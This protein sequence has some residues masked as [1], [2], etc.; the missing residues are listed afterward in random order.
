MAS[1]AASAASAASASSAPSIDSIGVIGVIDVIDTI[2][3]LSSIGGIGVIGGIGGIGGIGVISSIGIIKIFIKARNPSTFAVIVSALCVQ[4]GLRCVWCYWPNVHIFQNI[5]SW[6]VDAAA[7]SSTCAVMRKTEGRRAKH[8]FKRM[9]L[10]FAHDA[11][12]VKKVI[13]VFRAVS[14]ITKTDQD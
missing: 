5:Q 12:S 14:E 7:V 13:I 2:S 3:V 4:Q 6:N 8:I 11:R 1:S 10:C 9:Q